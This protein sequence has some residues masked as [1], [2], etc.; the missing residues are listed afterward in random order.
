[1]QGFLPYLRAHIPLDFYLWLRA[2]LPVPAAKFQLHFWPLLGCSCH[3]TQVST[4][5][6][7]DDDD[8]DD[9]TCMP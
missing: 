1:M 4:Y 8:D 3:V 2:L 5:Y 6:S 7:D 9:D